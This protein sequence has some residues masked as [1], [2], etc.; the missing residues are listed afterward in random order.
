M[1]QDTKA[2]SGFSTNDIQKTKEVYRGKITLRDRV[3]T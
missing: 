3:G 1:F 2:Y